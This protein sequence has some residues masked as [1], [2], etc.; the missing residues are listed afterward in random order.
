MPI[1]RYNMLKVLED[2][3]KQ[4]REALDLPKGLAVSKEI[5]N[6]VISG[7][8]GSAIGGD[9]LKSYMADSKIPVF[10]SRDYAL[11]GFVDSRSLVFVVSYSGNTEETLSSYYDAVNK[12]AN[13]IALTSG[14]E[15]ANLCKRTIKLPSGMQP[16]AAIGYLF[17]PI[18]GVLFNSGIVDISNKELNEMLMALTNVHEFKNKADTLSK[19]IRGKIPIIYSS[20]LLKP[21][22]YRWKCQIN[23]N[24]K[25]SAFYN[26]FSEMNHNELAGY[27]F[28]D[29][30]YA[31]IMIRDKKDNERIKK[32]M[33]ICRDIM[34]KTVEVEEVNTQGEYLL[35]RLFSGIYLGDWLSYFIALHNRIDPT[36]VEIIEGL[37]K[38]LAS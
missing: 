7:M 19:S 24:S 35:T 17:F 26:T 8:G 37:K 36:P 16:R 4:C 28:M 33:D 25:Q 2:F 30:K 27:K 29:R 14:G 34:E 3:P 38:D 13:I 21:V 20:E 12:K 23:E 32:R 1:D 10:V 11:P 18:L 22:A 31:A 6:I 9:L 5:N 15:L